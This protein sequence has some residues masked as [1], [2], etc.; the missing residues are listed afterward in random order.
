MFCEEVGNKIHKSVAS[1]WRYLTTLGRTACIVFDQDILYSKYQEM[2]L[3][4]WWQHRKVLL[5]R[6]PALRSLRTKDPVSFGCALEPCSCRITPPN[7]HKDYEKWGGDLL[8][9][10]TGRFWKAFHAVILQHG[11]IWH[12]VG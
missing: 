4:R 10:H 12:G 7:M 5:T 11:V 6:D 8:K 9:P 1:Y 3:R 2:I